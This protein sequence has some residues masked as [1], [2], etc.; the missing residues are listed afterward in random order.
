MDLI[1]L[2]KLLKVCY[3]WWVLSSLIMIDRVHWIDKEKL[4][5][6]ILN[7]QVTTAPNLRFG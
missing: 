4:A 6:F 7:C 2:L 5:K 3:S 1:E